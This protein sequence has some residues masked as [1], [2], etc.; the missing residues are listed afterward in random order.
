MYSDISSNDDDLFSPSKS[1]SKKEQ[2]SSLA[3][4]VEKILKETSEGKIDATLVRAKLAHALYDTSNHFVFSVDSYQR[5]VF[6]VL[7]HLTNNTYA[8]NFYADVLEESIAKRIVIF[9]FLSSITK[10]A[11]NEKILSFLADK[12]DINIDSFFFNTYVN[13][14]GQMLDFIINYNIDIY[15]KI[16]QHVGRPPVESIVSRNVDALDPKLMNSD[17]FIIGSFAAI[18]KSLGFEY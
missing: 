8:Y 13:S 18:R 17:E 15:V 3:N 11:S 16:C 6:N 14:M 12:M 10:S 7:N 2:T 1:S 5:T 9:D 4:D